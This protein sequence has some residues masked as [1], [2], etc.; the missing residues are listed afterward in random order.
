MEMEIK[1]SG[2][3]AL[4]DK[5]NKMIVNVGDNLKQIVTDGCIQIEAQAKENCP[6]D[7][8]YLR[9]HI[10]HEVKIDREINEVTGKVGTNTEYARR[11]EFGFNGSDKLGRKYNQ[12]ARPYLLP[13]YDKFKNIINS[14]IQN[15]LKR[16]VE[17]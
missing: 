8:G 5:L 10:T 3:G 15:E 16:T 2:T 7:T 11:I 13:A 6:V 4:F 14:K 1:I 9:S 12:K 17:K